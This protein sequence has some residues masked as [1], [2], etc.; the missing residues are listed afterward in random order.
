MSD[1]PIFEINSIIKRFNSDMN[2]FEDI[3]K[4]DIASYNLGNKIKTIKQQINKG[5]LQGGSYIN[6]PTIIDH[7]MSHKGNTNR[8]SNTQNNNSYSY[9]YN[10]F[11]KII[12][13]INIQIHNIIKI[14]LTEFN[15]SHDI[16]HFEKNDQIILWCLRTLLFYQL[17][18]IT[19]LMMQDEITF[20]DVYKNYSTKRKFKFDIINELENYKL[21][22]F[23][24]IT[25][26]SDIDVGVQYS[27]TNPTMIGLSYI[28]SVFEDLF[29]IFT[30]IDSL[31]FDIETYADMM[32]LPNI[33]ESTKKQ[34]PDIF[35]LDTSEFNETNFN[36][37]LPYI[38][39][40]ILRNYVTAKK[41]DN[42]D[43]NDRTIISTIISTFV[44]KDFYNNVPNI[45]ENIKN[46]YL[47]NTEM[48]ELNNTS[49]ELITDYMGSEYDV[50]REKYYNYVNEA[51]KSLIYVK[52]KYNR[53][54]VVN[55]LPDKITEIMQKIAKSLIYRAESYTCAP[56]VMHVVRVLQA[57][58]NNPDKYITLKPGYCQTNKD[59]DA[60]CSIGVYG[61]LISIYEQLGY[62][63]RFHITYCIETLPKEYNEDKCKNKRKKYGDRFDNAILLIDQISKKMPGGKKKKNKNKTR[64]KTRNTKRKNKSYKKRYEKKDMKKKI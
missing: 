57:N 2:K 35:Y 20:D 61:Y 48:D 58:A 50:A 19:T 24:S 33:D 53:E 29:L 4:N 47:K 51:E 38:E 18:I 39:A 8:T 45:P 9:S 16:I 5:N 15:Y 56:T 7:L 12:D 55:L 42:G 49:I 54:K 10:N 32:T 37:L 27:G 26:T 41:I 59:K 62:I 14:D 43:K 3:Y 63:Y 34:Y 60:Y 36:A 30:G 40:S 46:S 23:G 31:H 28:V 44:Y 11:K 1:Y 6:Q 22:I 17:L 52:E 13:L 25:P 64:A 21:G